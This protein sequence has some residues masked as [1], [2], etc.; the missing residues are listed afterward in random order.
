M[1]RNLISKTLAEIAG[2]FVLVFAG[3]G[4][5]MIQTRYGLESPLWVTPLVFG[6]AVALMIYAVRHI[7]GAHFNPAVTLA[8]AVSRHFPKGQVLIY[9]AA[10]LVGAFA[11]IA[12]LKFILPAGSLYGATIPQVNS[13][14]SVIWEI[15]LTFQLMFVITAVATDSRAQGIPAS[16]AIGAAVMLGALVGGPVTGASMNPARSLAPAVFQGT[17]DSVGIYFVGPFLG[18]VLA[19]LFY[20]LIRCESDHKVKTVKGCC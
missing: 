18:A 14:A 6:L 5:I 9:W 2:T 8:F 10:Q 17:L 7:S 4:S 19:V 3:C 1:N 11:A 16:I 15:L 13:I 12:L 20:N